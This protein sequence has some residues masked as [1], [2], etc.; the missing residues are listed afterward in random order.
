MVENTYNGDYVIK[1][2]HF[3]SHKRNNKEQGLGIESVRKTVELHGGSLEIYPFDN[4]FQA[5]IV[6]PVISN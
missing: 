5:G 1:D 2:N 4:V 6:L 3:L